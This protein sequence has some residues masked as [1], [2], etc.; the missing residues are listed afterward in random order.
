M[1]SAGASFDRVTRLAR[2]SPIEIFA[3][4]TS[5]PSTGLASDNP[6]VVRS[7]KLASNGRRV[8]CLDPESHRTEHAQQIVEIAEVVTEHPLYILFRCAEKVFVMN[9]RRMPET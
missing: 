7:C 2:V 4:A 6:G 9:L 3:S 8:S 5:V 1:P